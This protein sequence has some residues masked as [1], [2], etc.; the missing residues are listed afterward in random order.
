MSTEANKAVVT[1]F[2][3]SF[4]ARDVERGLSL[5]TDDVSWWIAGKPEQLRSA[6]LYDKAKLH[7]LFRRM[8]RN[9]PD[10]LRMTVKGLVAEGDKVAAEATS[11]GRLENGRVYEQEYHFLFTLHDGKITTVREY[12]DTQHVH[13]IWELPA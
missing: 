1:E 2:F 5:L 10:G 12:L 8:E 13:T 6:G 7:K 9:L 3:E 11:Y 4:T